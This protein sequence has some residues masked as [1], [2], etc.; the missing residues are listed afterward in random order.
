M[1]KKSYLLITRFLTLNINKI[2]SLHHDNKIFIIGDS[3]HMHYTGTLQDGTE[4]DSSI[5]RYSDNIN[6]MHVIFCTF[7]KT[8]LV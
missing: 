3:L 7:K 2:N 1:Q 8:P 4:F 6:D 5:T